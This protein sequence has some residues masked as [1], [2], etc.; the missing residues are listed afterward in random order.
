MI[1]LDEALE[2]ILTFA[3]PLASET[4]DLKNA[5]N[6]FAAAPITAKLSQPPFD[7]SAMDGYA[8]RGEEAKAGTTLE[9]IGTSK[10]GEGFQGEVGPGECVRIFTGA[11]VPEGADTI[12]M[13]EKTAPRG[14][15]I[16][17]IEDCVPGQSIRKLGNDFTKGD[18]VLNSGDRLTPAAIA[19]AAAANN[20][21]IDVYRQPKIALLAT[22]DELVAPGKDLGDHQIVASNSSALCALMSPL[23]SKVED[24][25]IVPD[26][27]NHL[28][29]VLQTALDGDTDIIV[30]TGGASV[31]DHDI[32]QPVL[33]SLG[34]EMDFWRIAM[35]PGK[36]LMFGKKGSK[37]V[38]GLPG[39]P[40]SALVT[41]TIV[42]LPA[43]RAL[44]GSPD[45]M[46]QNL[47][48]PLGAPLP[49]NGPRRHFIRAN[50][51]TKD[52][53]I[54]AVYPIAQTDSAHLSSIAAANALIVH[55][56]NAEAMKAGDLVE[57][58]P[59][60]LS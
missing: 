37:L 33:K 17:F 52:N 44:S 8:V 1:S 27:V 6:R 29:A 60:T 22:G 41:A 20:A 34:V 46:G 58:I 39:N 28:T 35:R 56:E 13:Q 14:T 53:G 25:G 10:A 59:I 9:M 47:S 7:A 42:V 48:L 36:P 26:N 57:I 15:K 32:V 43:L 2:R 54:S 4:L 18:T 21:Q 50:V 38:F 24:L 51:Q 16:M 23:A 19:L 45:P 40:V 5:A 3:D 49:Q 55:K 11:P 31:G 12:V 30:T